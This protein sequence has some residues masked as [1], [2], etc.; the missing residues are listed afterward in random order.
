MDKSLI[1]QILPLLIPVAIIQLT[2]LIIALVDLVR[3]PRA[4]LLP[5]WAWVLIIVLVN[6]IGPIVYLIIGREE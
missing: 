4:K 5:K 3:R 2:L 6:L 1:L